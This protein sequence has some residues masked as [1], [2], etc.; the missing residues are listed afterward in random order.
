ETL[1]LPARVRVLGQEAYA[2]LLA[3]MQ[4]R[5]RGKD[6]VIVPGGPLGYLPFELLVDPEGKYLVETRR[7]RYAPSLTVLHL[8]RQWEQQRRRP[9]R[10]LWA[11]GDPIFD[12][13][14]ERL[15]GKG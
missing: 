4:E 5:L 6:L 11:L 8:G 9:Q 1:A 3:P 12:T 14:D 10:P 2:K 15:Q 13:T 7:I